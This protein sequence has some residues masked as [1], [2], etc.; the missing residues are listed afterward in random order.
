MFKKIKMEVKGGQ[1]EAGGT[2]GGSSI[3]D[4]GLGVEYVDMDEDDSTEDEEES[5]EEMD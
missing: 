1:V 5:V 2:L 4:D 3:F